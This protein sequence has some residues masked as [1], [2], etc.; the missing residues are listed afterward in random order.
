MMAVTPLVAIRSFMTG[1][2][3]ATY[4][5]VRPGSSDQDVVTGLNGV[6]HVMSKIPLYVSHP[7]HAARRSSILAIWHRHTPPG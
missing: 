7:G 6:N 2:N 3:R 4:M 5:A 1:A